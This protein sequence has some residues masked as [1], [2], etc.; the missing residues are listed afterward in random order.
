[1][2]LQ[3][4]QEECAEVIQAISKINRFG[5]NYQ[6]DTTGVFNS[7]HL[8]TELTDVL[9]LIDILVEK[10]IITFGTGEL[11]LGKRVKRVRIVKYLGVSQ[12]A[13]TLDLGEDIQTI[14]Y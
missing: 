8:K 14:L 12:R 2:L 6:H 7:D 1:M 5:I 4:V 13:G 3:L 10:E 9:T 11:E